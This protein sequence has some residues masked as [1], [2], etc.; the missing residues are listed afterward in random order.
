MEPEKLGQKISRELQDTI[1]KVLREYAETLALAI[2]LAIILRIFV[3]SA[4]RISN[5]TMIPSLRVGDFIVGYKLPYGFT[6]PFTEKKIGHPK[7]KKNDLLIFRCP[8]NTL[9]ACVKRVVALPGDRVEI[10]NKMLIVN[11]EVAKYAKIDLNLPDLVPQPPVYAVLRESIGGVTRAIYI[12]GSDLK[13]AFGPYIVPPDHFFALSDN[14]DGVDDS[15]TW[16]AIPFKFIEA[17]AFLTWFSLDWSPTVTEAGS[18]P[19]I[20]PE[21]IFHRLH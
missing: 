16:G 17:R 20:R 13:E 18:G 6:I 12:T 14:R 21:R 1:K 11:G 9:V 7:P 8:N 10:Q 19:R 4:Y 2:L 5:P 3:L 15:R